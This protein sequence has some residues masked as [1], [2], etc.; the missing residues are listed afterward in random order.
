VTALERAWYRAG[1]WS[2]WL[3]PLAWLFAWVAGKRRAYLEARQARGRLPVIVVGNLTVGGTGKTPLIIA[4]VKALQARGYRPGVIS[5][6]YGG[7]APLYPMRVTADS[8]P[9]QSGDEPLLIAL[10]CDCPVVVDPDRVRAARYLENHTDCEIILSD[11]GLQ[12][13]RLA[14]DMEII[15][16]D[17]DRVLGNGWCLPAGPLREPLARLR[18]ADFAIVNGG[19]AVLDHPRQY[20]MFLQPLRFRR[21]D[22][23]ESRAVDDPPGDSV[24]AVAGIGNPTRFAR[25]LASL[26]LA[27]KLHPFPDHHRFSA[28][29]LRFGDGRPV[30]LTAKDAVKCQHLPAPNT[31]VLDVAATLENSGMHTLVDAIES[32]VTQL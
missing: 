25:T 2:L 14:R 17:G 23:S 12:H 21:L 29:E 24:N 11:D 31:W 13:Y 10:S 15:V 27:V 20:R 6:G 1:S 19:N 28:A 3:A 9:A 16:V 18:E 32:R 5:R 22:G 7:R 8:D 26:G 30:I 4:L